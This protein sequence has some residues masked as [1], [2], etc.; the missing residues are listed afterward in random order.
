MIFHLIYVI[1]AQF[2]SLSTETKL[3]KLTGPELVLIW[4]Y[5]KQFVIPLTNFADSEAFHDAPSGYG[6]TI[7]KILKIDFCDVIT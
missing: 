5:L 2:I 4:S 3:Q 1:L 7:S 6:K